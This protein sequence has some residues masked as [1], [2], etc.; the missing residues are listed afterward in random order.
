VVLFALKDKRHLT[1]LRYFFATIVIIVVVAVAATRVVAFR[2]RGSAQALAQAPARAVSIEPRLQQLTD[3]QY[4]VGDTVSAR[5]SIVNRLE[6]PVTVKEIGTS[7]SCM[8]TLPETASALPFDIAPGGKVEFWIKGSVRS[9][10]EPEQAYSIRV[11]AW[12]DQAPLPDCFASLRFHVVDEL[13]AYPPAVKLGEVTA[14]QPVHRRIYLYTLNTGPEQKVPTLRVSS[15]Q[16]IT[17]SITPQPTLS[18]GEVPSDFK[19]RFVVD[20]NISPDKGLADISEAI[21]ILPD[22]QAPLTI[23]VECSYKKECRISA[24]H[25]DVEGAPGQLL[26]REIFLESDSPNWQN[27][28]VRASPQEVAVIVE[29]FDAKTK[30]IR[31]TIRIP[32]SE[33]SKSGEIVIQSMDTTSSIKIPVRLQTVQK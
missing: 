10:P 13:K 21:A 18:P 3:R 5:F 24:N 22:N 4:K 6:H 29:S 1:Y 12:S 25:L 23:P 8:A 7:C 32:K 19:V 14:G 2:G 9:T 33:V 27:I 15:P 11:E 26:T 20:V 30:V 28:S 31:V 16:S 17:A